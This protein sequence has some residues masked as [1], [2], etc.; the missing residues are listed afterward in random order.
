MTYS[1]CKS[2]T[3]FGLTVLGRER[4]ELR[5][6]YACT[7]SYDNPLFF[8]YISQCHQHLDVWWNVEFCCVGTLKQEL[9]GTCSV[10]GSSF[11]L[12][13]HVWHGVCMCMLVYSDA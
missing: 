1:C 2:K 10:L 3:T 11:R 4:E 5:K 12:F 9:A 8:K 7:D 13:L 6:L